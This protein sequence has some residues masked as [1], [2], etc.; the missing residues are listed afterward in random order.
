MCGPGA[1]VR[2]T[3]SSL[4]CLLASSKKS[5]NDEPFLQGVQARLANSN[6]QQLKPAVGR[7][8]RLLQLKPAVGKTGDL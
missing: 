2:L 7:T 3:F 8:A 6:A 4:V 1:P 5:E